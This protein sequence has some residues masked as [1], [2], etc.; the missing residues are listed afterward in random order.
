LPDLITEL[1][2]DL[3]GK[4]YRSPLPFSWLFDPD[5]EIMNLYRQVGVET[6]VML[7][8]IYET[9]DLTGRDM[10]VYYE[11]QGYDVIYTPVEDFSVPEPGLFEKTV[12]KALAAVRAGKTLA[13][14]CHAGIG[15]T[16]MFTACMAKIV[17]GFSGA[18]A[19]DWV[20]QFIPDAVENRF[21]Y[22]FVTRFDL[23]A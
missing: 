11:E 14:H 1:P 8:P 21:Q 9:K 23:V 12:P 17:F 6:I 5:H 15:R 22:R 18:E 4:V 2:Y 10:G 20:R 7:T 16:G 13:V 3:P 19:V